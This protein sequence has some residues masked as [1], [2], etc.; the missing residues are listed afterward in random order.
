ME[1]IRGKTFV[2]KYI[3]LDNKYFEDCNIRECTLLYSG[4]QFRISNTSINQVTVQFC[5]AA[6]N[7]VKLLKQCQIDPQKL[8]F[9]QTQANIV[10]LMSLK[11]AGGEQ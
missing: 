8:G 6:E 1:I 10:D 7:T 5:G 11:S 9:L 2:G 3:V 4:K